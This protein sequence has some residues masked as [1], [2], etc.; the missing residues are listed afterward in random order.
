MISAVRLVSSELAV[1]LT[2]TLRH[3]GEASLADLSRILDATPSSTQRALEIL[4]ADA[5]VKSRGQGRSRRFAL[6]ED[7]PLL[8]PVERL[9]MALIDTR[10]L[11]RLV[12]R[13]NPAVE[14]IGL[15][16]T[17]IVVV[18]RKRSRAMD[19]S[20]AAKAAK[21]LQS[22]L[23][24]RT[25]FLYHED[26]RRPSAANDQL[27]VSLAS[28]EILVGDVEV[29]LPDRSGHR[30]GSG[31]SLRRISPALQLP[32]ART[33][34]ALKHRHGVHRLR[35]FG[36]AVRSDFRP[37]SDVDI[38][39]ELLPDANDSL[40]VMESL[41]QELERRLGRDVDLVLEP[42]LHPAVGQLVNKEAVTL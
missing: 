20:R 27:R 3:A 38:V 42:N 19:Q 9:A 22:E 36:S 23:K 37:D 33:I 15:T 8:D 2:V 13:T 41:E 10:E 29:S 34:Q 14:F 18:F 25:R 32:S 28:G 5:I 26:L 30:R 24:R 1:K 12:G 16:S 17:E 6:N 39:V 11:L 21:R 7:S 35:V 4:L 40:E 31:T